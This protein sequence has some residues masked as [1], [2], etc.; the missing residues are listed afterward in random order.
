MRFIHKKDGFTLMELMIVILTGSIVT[1]AAT[2]ILLL[3]FRINRK[4]LDTIER[5]S[6]TRIVLSV[7]ENMSFD[8]DYELINNYVQEDD[9]ELTQ[10]LV[11]GQPQDNWSINSSG[12][13]VIAYQQPMNGLSG[14]IISSGGH[15]L[16]DKVTTSMLYKPYTPFRYVNDLYTFSAK[17]DGVTYNSTVYSRTQDDNWGADDPMIDYEESRKIMMEVLASQIG[18]AGAIIEAPDTSYARWYSTSNGDCWTEDQIA[19]VEQNSWCGCFVS[20]A[21]NKVNYKIPAAQVPG[22][23]KK[24]IDPDKLPK[25]A[26]VNFL[27]LECY[28]QSGMDNLHVYGDGYIPQPGDLIFF[29]DFS[30]H[31]TENLENLRK[32]DEALYA[33]PDDE[34]HDT[35]QHELSLDKGNYYVHAGHNLPFVETEERCYITKRAYDLLVEAFQGTENADGHP[36]NYYEPYNVLKHFLNVTGDGM[37][38][39]G[40]VTKV[41]DGYVY[42]VEG[43]VEIGSY[44]RVVM[45]KYPLINEDPDSTLYPFL[46]PNEYFHIFGYATLNWLGNP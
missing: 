1:M 12:S 20:W 31:G 9:G 27:W 26:N 16:V 18:S 32:L 15:T 6:V 25:E 5:Q 2:T 42:T 37:D 14:K 3:A 41:K 36:S 4:S 35:V 33:I 19:E 10:V 7:L 43:N 46:D 29:T 30:E 11:G 8:G 23:Y 45:R 28:G 22:E 17:I 34:R 44:T 24:Y 40:I 21:I 13:P 38:H 39:V